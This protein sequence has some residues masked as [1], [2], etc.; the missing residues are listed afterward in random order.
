MTVCAGRRRRDPAAAEGPLKLAMPRGALF[1]RHARRA[2]RGRGRHLA[3]LRSDSRSL[4]FETP[5]A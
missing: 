5:G 4:V 3:A 1:E 2:R